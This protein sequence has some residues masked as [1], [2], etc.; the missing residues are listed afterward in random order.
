MDQASIMLTFAVLMLL[1][2][3][4]VV[5]FVVYHMDLLG[6]PGFPKVTKRRARPKKDSE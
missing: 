5:G 6:Y 1:A 3:I 4:V 2:A